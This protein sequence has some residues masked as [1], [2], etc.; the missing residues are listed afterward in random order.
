MRLPKWSVPALGMVCTGLIGFGIG[1]RIGKNKVSP[2]IVY[3]P[4]K[5]DPEPEPIIEVNE[6]Q[7]EEIKA[8]KQPVVVDKLVLDAETKD[9]IDSQREL[10]AK[11]LNKEIDAIRE[12]D[13]EILGRPEVNNVFIEH[14]DLKAWDYDEELANRK[15]DE[16]YVIHKDEF[17]ENEH[18]YNQETLTFYAGDEIM[19]DQTD[20]PMYG[21]FDMMGTLKFG[22]GSEDPN[23]VYIRNDVLHYE[24]EILRHSGRFE[25]EVG[26]FSIEQEYEQNDLKHANGLYKFREF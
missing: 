14:Y 6:E 15:P 5:P 22:H 8:M 21:W 23:V 24:W 11:L 13:K 26:G 10:K 20:A 12:H 4:P 2:T 9:L 25:V 18:D 1:H 3:M 16:P 7:V 19:A 17:M